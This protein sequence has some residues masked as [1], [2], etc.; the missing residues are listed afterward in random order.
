MNAMT[1]AH[2]RLGVW[3]A[4]VASAAIAMACDATV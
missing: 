3:L 4:L 2:A 1:H